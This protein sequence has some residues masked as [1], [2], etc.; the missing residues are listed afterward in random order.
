MTPA[1]SKMMKSFNIARSA[2]ANPNAG[3]SRDNYARGGSPRAGLAKKSARRFAPAA[4]PSIAAIALVTLFIAAGH[5]QWEKAAAKE[6]WQKALDERGAQP[7][8]DLNAAIAAGGDSV[9][10]EDLALRRVAA[11]GRFEPQGQ[12][13]VDNRVHQGQAGYHVVTPLRLEGSELRVLVNRGW[14]K[15]AAE[16]GALPQ[17][18]APEGLVAISGIAV[19][20]PTRFFTLG[21]EEPGSRRW[22]HLDLGRYIKAAAHP[23]LP[24][25]VE[26]D[27]QS[28]GGFVR[29][30]RRP[31]ER[32]FTNLGYALQWWAFAATTAVIWIVLSWR[33]AR[34]QAP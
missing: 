22:Q 12:I 2:N 11:R 14:L 28:A 18:Q 8:I 13:Y 30:W 4:W 5:W 31:D 33:R 27:A 6:R 3:S 19:I 26:L 21:S 1:K 7:A 20:P 23:V 10:A 15:A 24:V 16:H 9:K 32:I 29:A 17:A 34:R 25:V